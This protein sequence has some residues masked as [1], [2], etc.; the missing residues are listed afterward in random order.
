[1]DGERLPGENWLTE[2][3]HQVVDDWQD[4]SDVE[5]RV[6]HENEVSS[7]KLW[8]SFQNSASSITQL[9]RGNNHESYD[10][11]YIHN[12]IYQHLGTKSIL[13]ISLDL[14]LESILSRQTADSAQI[15]TDQTGS[16][17]YIML[18][19]A[20]PLLSSPQEF[21]R[22]QVSW[23]HF[24]PVCNLGLFTSKDDFFKATQQ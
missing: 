13:E 4:G 12:K 22:T 6:Q 23:N 18:R 24:V 3:E 16:A 5:E 10:Q 1:M 2:W 17:L 7:Q 20:V 11:I 9:Y 14:D 15:K 8:L 19:L 21:L